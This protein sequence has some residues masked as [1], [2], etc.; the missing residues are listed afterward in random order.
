MKIRSKLLTKIVANVVVVVFKTLF[1]TCK[2]KL[3]FEVPESN[4]LEAEKERFLISVW[5]HELVIPVLIVPQKNTAA[6]VSQHQ[7]GSYLAEI[8]SRV[9]ITPVRGSSS[10]GGA[11]AIKQLI[12]K[13]ED[14]SIVITPDGPRGPRQEIKSG[15]VFLASQTGRGIL[16]TAYACNRFWTIKGS[17][18]D[19][20]IPK[21]F[22]KM[23]ACVGKPI[24][25][26]KKIR[27]EQLDHY[28]EIVQNAMDDL[29]IQA[30]NI[31]KG[32]ANSIEKQSDQIDKKTDQAETPHAA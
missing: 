17:W 25:V 1:L 24:Y 26:P 9:G 18:T 8:M 27:R 19:Q 21:P 20:V 14:H 29:N 16:P 31:S 22:S 2:K 23:T 12:E 10:K 4:Y 6:L 7:D 5:H 32:F 11:R 15:I 30:Q 13:T 28:T 3:L